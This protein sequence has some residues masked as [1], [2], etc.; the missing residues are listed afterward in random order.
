MPRVTVIEPTV[1]PITKAP[2]YQ[3]IKRKVAA[4]ARVSTDSDEQYTSYEAQVEYYTKYIQEKEDWCYV[5]TFADEGISG[6]STKGRKQFNEMI[7]RALNG[8]IDLIITKSISRFARNTL[9]TISKIRELKAHNVEVYFEKENIWT[10]DP[11]SELILTI[12]ASI[13]QEESRSISQNVTWGKRVAFQKG[14]VTISYRNFLGYKRGAD[15]KAEIDESQAKTVRMIYKMFLIDGLTCLN[16]AKKLKAMGVETATGTHSWSRNSVVSILTNEKYKGDALLQKLYVENYLDHKTVKNNGVL[17]KY[18]VEN[19]HPAIIEKEVWDMVQVEMARRLKIGDAY[20]SSD[21][22]ATKLICEDCGGFYGRKVWHSNDVHRKIIYQCN[23]KFDYEK[24][25]FKCHTPHLTEDEI[26]QK[27]LLAYNQIMTQKDKVIEDLIEVAELLGDDSAVD[28]QINEAN[29]ELEEIETL[30]KALVEKRTKTS[31]VSEEE[32]TSKYGNYEKRFNKI[33][34]RINLLLK[35][36][37]LKKGKK[38]WILSIVSTLQKEPNQILKWNKE[39]WMLM[40]E[41]AIIHKNKTITFKFHSGQEV[42]V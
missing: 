1:N 10:F 13:A 40:V 33:V 26:I 2:I 3:I 27:Y 4:Y 19:S 32:F 17:P 42:R 6:T 30:M 23:H 24:K 37:E 39:T 34:E 25:E 11:K 12:M 28:N 14:K 16:I 15:G 9:D 21:I 22:F 41:S 36:K 7:E 38:N 18:Y 35:E 31:D 8:E 20:S 5:N 29:S